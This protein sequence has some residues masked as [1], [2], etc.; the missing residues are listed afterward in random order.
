MGTI[1]KDLIGNYTFNA[2]EKSGGF[3]DF[4]VNSYLSLEH[5]MKK[6]EEIFEQK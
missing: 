3:M 2:S 5:D 6:R 1:L 4:C